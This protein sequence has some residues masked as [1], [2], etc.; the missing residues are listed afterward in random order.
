MILAREALRLLYF[1]TRI[2]WP[3]SKGMLRTA[4]RAAAAFTVVV[5]FMLG[6]GKPFG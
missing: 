6:I 1:S 2:L 4:Q 5:T 3:I